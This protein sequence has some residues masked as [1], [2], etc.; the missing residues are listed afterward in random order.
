MLDIYT[1]DQ[2]VQ[3]LCA[4]TNLVCSIGNIADL[5]H[6]N[7]LEVVFYY[8]GLIGEIDSLDFTLDESEVS[9]LREFK[10]YLRPYKEDLYRLINGDIEYLDFPLA[11]SKLKLNYLALFENDPDQFSLSNL[12]EKL[13][14][15]IFSLQKE[16]LFLSKRKLTKNMLRI[17]S[18]SLE[19]FLHSPE[20]SNSEDVE[21]RSQQAI[22]IMALL[23]S[24]TK[25]C[26]KSGHKP[27]SKKIGELIAKEAT[28]FFPNERGFKAFNKKI[29]DCLKTFEDEL[30]SAIKSKLKAEI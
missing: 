5:V 16:N 17:T 30:P 6:T 28:N 10:G 9:N 23:L 21:I 13:P 4:S 24:E 8:E 15:N 11:I 22:A 2:A 19:A 1:L 29:S 7:K 12:L 20:K 14:S 3:K 25:D 27:N 18:E 26:Y